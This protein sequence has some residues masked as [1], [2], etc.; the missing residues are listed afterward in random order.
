M[1]SYFLLG[2]SKFVILVAAVQSVFVGDAVHPL[3]NGN[4]LTMGLFKVT[5]DPGIVVFLYVA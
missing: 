4:L 1:L 2:W 3:I 5:Y